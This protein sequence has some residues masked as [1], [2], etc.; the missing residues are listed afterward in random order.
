[1]QDHFDNFSLA[2]HDHVHAGHSVAMT[3]R[4]FSPLCL[5][6]PL[7]DRLDPIDWATY[8]PYFWSNAQRYAA[9]VSVLFGSLMQLQRAGAEPGGTSTSRS[10]LGAGAAPGGSISASFGG[11]GSGVS[12][13][14]ADM[15]PLSLLPVA[16]RFQYLPISTPTAAGAGGA[17]SVS[18][19]S[20]SL[21]SSTPNLAAS[22][23]FGG[24]AAAGAAAGG[25]GQLGGAS[26]ARVGLT[27]A[28]GAGLS[29]GLAG[30]SDLA[31]SFSFA[32]LGGARGAGATGLTA[33]AAAAAGGAAGAAT[34]GEAATAGMA[35]GASAL[36][37]LQ[38][39]FQTGSLGS[40]GTMLVGGTA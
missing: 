12:G 5:S 31:G 20:G 13:S 36:S 21:A 25:H 15:N 24:L 19:L 16:P 1:M 40:F 3:L 22:G 18:P 35:A 26:R 39:R 23:S 8:E 38:A 29:V 27:A 28:T 17:A 6:P 30:S 9:R 33:G 14:S 10:F 2:T 32:D 34:F 37:A 11:G 7:Q 4:S